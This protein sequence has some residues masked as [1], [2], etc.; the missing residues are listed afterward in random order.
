MIRKRK[1]AKKNKQ[2]NT[3]LNNLRNIICL[4]KSD[5]SIERISIC[6][7]IENW[8]SMAYTVCHAPIQ[9]TS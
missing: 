2:K 5:I 4:R 3:E 1:E 8:W 7:V 9:M 6:N